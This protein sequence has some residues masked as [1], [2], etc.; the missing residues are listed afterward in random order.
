MTDPGP[1]P[2]TAGPTPDRRL[3]PRPLP[4]HLATAM[5]GWTSS[6]AALPL[7]RNGS[8]DWRPEVAAAAQSLRAALDAASPQERQPAGASPEN[9]PNDPFDRAVEAEVVRRLAAFA[10]GIRQY[11]DHPYR[12]ALADPPAIWRDGT[13]RLLD[14][15]ATVRAGRG[16][17]AR[18]VLFVPSLVNRAY[19]LD[20]SAK[21]SLLRWL[22]RERPGG[23]ALRPLLIDW[24]A[25]GETERGFDLTAY[26]DGRLGDALKAARALDPLDRPVP[27]V[28]YCMGGLLAM[29]LALRRPDD[30][31]ALGLLATPWD[32]HTERV[33][34]A[35]AAAAACRAATPV[36]AAL[37][38]LPVN[39]LQSLF[40]T[41]DP[42]LVPRKFAVFAG[43][44]PASDK[45]ADFVALEDWLNDGVGLAAAVA[46]ECIEG[47]YGDNAPH[48]GLW[49]VG[50]M[51][52]DPARW[53]KPALAL[54][55]QHDR[56]VPPASAQALADAL[57]H[58]TALSPRLGHIGMVA[59]AAARDTVWQP[60]ADWLGGL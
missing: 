43:L 16:G 46:R 58:A 47:W 48:R 19:I 11:R 57:P 39:A 41:L 27:V 6:R 15:G 35:H 45:A 14:Y 25:P 4:L 3:A 17:P 44:D 42:F 10:A 12:R 54:I 37:G 22:A 55:P 34:A 53:T 5:N 2:Q 49:R 24:D 18:P 38:E 52:I 1:I 9:P 29:A 56:I 33:A 21:R 32:F 60:L 20:L 28:G 31:A 50:G 51:A 36:L 40:A 26:I 13:T 7:L 23:T 30:V 8:L 59:G